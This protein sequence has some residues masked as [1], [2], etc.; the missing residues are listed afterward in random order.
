MNTSES[1]RPNSARL[2]KEPIGCR[3][4]ALRS[5]NRCVQYLCLSTPF[6][7]YNKVEKEKQPSEEHSLQRTHCSPM[8]NSTTTE[9]NFPSRL[10]HDNFVVSF[11]K[12]SKT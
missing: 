12:L 10:H 3:Q 1:M 2:K 9:N 7:C 6:E 11:N 8:E 5:K 4:N